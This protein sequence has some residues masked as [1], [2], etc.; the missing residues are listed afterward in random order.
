MTRRA[1]GSVLTDKVKT[2]RWR[3]DQV[4]GPPEQPGRTGPRAGSPTIRRREFGSLIRGLRVQ[5]GWTME[6]VAELLLCS[7]SK[8]SRLES[9]QRGASARDVRDLCNIYEV[10]DEQRGR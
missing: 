7:P 4:A 10:S 5:R 3:C 8:V 6:Y 1:T 9:G 2:C